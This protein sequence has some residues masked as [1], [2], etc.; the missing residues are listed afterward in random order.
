MALEFQV[1]SLDTVEESLKSVYVE[2]DGKFTLD[3]DKYAEFKA[4]GLKNK[5]REL[6]GKLG[7]ASDGLKKFEKFAE[8]DDS[9]LDELLELR[10]NKDKPGDTKPADD[11]RL[12]QLEKQHKKALEKLTGEKGISDT[13]AAELEK[14][15][16]HYQLTIP[17]RDAALKAGVLPEDLEVVMLDTQKRFGLND[18]GKPVVL[19]E[20]GD[21]QDLSLDKFF[22]S[23]YKEQRPKF[24]APSGAG[25]SGAPANAGGGAHGKTLNRENFNKLSSPQQQTFIADVR[26][27]KA[28]LV[29]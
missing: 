6:L 11:E 10:A 29:D 24:Y 28:T 7:K 20:D 21:P 18:E 25:G 3:P 26:A 27:G 4:T 16:K 14:Q 8:F 17:V 15:V 22:S 9:D 2:K 1:D 13:R 19:D 5:N 12:A 23:L